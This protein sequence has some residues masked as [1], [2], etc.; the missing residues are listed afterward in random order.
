[1]C[2]GGSKVACLSGFYQDD[3]GKAECKVCPAGYK[4]QGPNGDA[5]V[6]ED[7]PYD[8]LA[9]C[10]QMHYCP[11][12]EANPVKCPAGHY[13]TRMTATTKEECLPCPAGWICHGRDDNTADGP[14]VA[15]F[16]E[17]E[18]GNYCAESTYDAVVGNAGGPVECGVGFYCPPG[19]VEKIPCPP[20]YA[21]TT[22]TLAAVPTSTPC[23]A[24]YYCPKGAIEQSPDD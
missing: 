24:G 19:V 6:G 12:T 11:G 22:P 15:T 4:C 3:Y 16:T 1:M 5:A 18:G 10:G 7:P 14:Y 13:T 17:C 21:C 8:H 23:T 9:S 2:T 20:G